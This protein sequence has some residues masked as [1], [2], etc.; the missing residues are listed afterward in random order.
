MNALS[1]AQKLMPTAFQIVVKCQF[2]IGTCRLPSVFL[3]V[4]VANQTPA[5]CGLQPTNVI[6][7][8]THQTKYLGRDKERII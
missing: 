6:P 5:Q 1:A 8:P 3:V 4:L 2:G 7:H